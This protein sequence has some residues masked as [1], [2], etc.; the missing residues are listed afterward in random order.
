MP[1]TK[2]TKKKSPATGWT[3]AHVTHEAMDQIGGIASRSVFDTGTDV[4]GF[5]THQW[6][7]LTL[8]V[9]AHQGSVGVV[10]F[11]ER[12]QRRGDRDDLL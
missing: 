11:E 10:V 12:D 3:V 1:K 5:G 9:G 8:H 7:G 6:H 4:G 2:A